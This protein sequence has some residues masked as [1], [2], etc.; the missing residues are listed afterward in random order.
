[1]NFPSCSSSLSFFN[2]PSS[3]TA[4]LSP[5]FTCLE[6]LAAR[7]STEAKSARASSVLIISI[8]EIGSNIMQ[9]LVA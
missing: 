6:I 8:S 2:A 7:L 1:M 5:D 3:I 4:S 9:E